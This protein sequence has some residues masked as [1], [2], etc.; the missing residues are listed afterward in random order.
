MDRYVRAVEAEARLRSTD[1]P[2][3]TLYFGGGTPSFIGVERLR[4]LM[5]AVRGAWRLEADCEITV[6]AN[7]CDVT[8]EWAMGCRAEGVNR[9]SVGAQGMRDDDL[10]FLGRAHTVADAVEAVKRARAAGFDNLSI[11]LIVGLPGHTA[12]ATRDMLRRAVET[13]APEH[14]SCY[15]LTVA[16]GTPLHKA[17]KRGEV[18]MPGQEREA[19]IFMATHETCAAL[20][21]E[22]YEVSNFARGAEYRSRH[23][24]AYWAHADYVGLGPSAHSFVRPVRWWNVE[25]AGEYCAALE[26]GESAEKGRESL[27]RGQLASEVVMLGLRTRDGFS[28][29][30]LREV[31]GT[32][33]AREKGALLGRAEAEGLLRCEGERV[34]PTLRGMAVADRLAVELAPEGE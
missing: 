28:L 22:G 13:F 24:S 9:L 11:D 15:Q 3:R 19:E 21:Y 29:A 26:R 14:L 20:G 30:E 10:R 5:R 4:G 33:L 17:V 27:T 7:P 18:R 16:Q 1:R 25:D 2:A 31:Y 6:E 12:E 34:A 8:P 23:N 32:D